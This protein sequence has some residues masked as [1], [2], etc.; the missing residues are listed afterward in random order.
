M[1]NTDRTFLRL[2]LYIN[3]GLPL[4]KAIELA[5]GEAETAAIKKG[6]LSIKTKIE[7][8]A[9]VAEG[10]R[11]V[12]VFRP[13]ADLV[14][15]GEETGL[16]EFAFEDI[17]RKP[18]PGAFLMW[19]H[20]LLPQKLLGDAIASAAAVLPAKE[21]RAVVAARDVTTLAEAAER[22]PDRFPAPAAAAFAGAPDDN[23]V[24]MKLLDGLAWAVEEG[25][26]RPS[27]KSL[28]DAQL[29][30]FMGLWLLIRA[31]VPLVDG[32]RA[33][34][35]AVAHP[36]MSKCLKTAADR[37]AAGS[38]L[39]EPLEASGLFSPSLVAMVQMAEE[40]GALDAASR[41]IAEGIAAG[42]FR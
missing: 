8:G 28:S 3:Y 41:K 34:S 1:P 36:K 24:R 33:L 5:A 23:D 30:T 31:G 15:V 40:C 38:T 16:L 18:G 4:L 10:M 20:R 2:A 21:R 22:L 9:S 14:A 37:L 35:D 32:V 17:A 42:L 27:T 13:F 19:L 26:F 39:T 11:G 29:R 25:L 6:L 7:T 12:S